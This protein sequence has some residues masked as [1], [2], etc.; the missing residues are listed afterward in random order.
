M[1]PYF[2]ESYSAFSTRSTLSNSKVKNTKN[3]FHSNEKFKQNSLR[4]QVNQ[5]SEAQQSNTAVPYFRNVV[6]HSGENA[7]RLSQQLNGSKNVLS[8]HQSV[9]TI[10]S[11]NNFVDFLVPSQI[12]SS[13]T[14][15][16]PHFSLLLQ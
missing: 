12:V 5:G 9:N 6:R 16:T 13:I 4:S 8:S 2:A 11:L 14:Q 15:T 3:K 1:Q 10:L 7:Q